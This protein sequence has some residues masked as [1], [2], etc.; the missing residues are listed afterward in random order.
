MSTPMTPE[1]KAWIDSATLYELLYKWRF[2]I[3]G[4]PYFQGD[5]GG[6]FLD[7]MEAKR[8]ANPHAWTQASKDMGWIG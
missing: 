3:S 4:D 2:A 7:V 5:T 8:K 6:Y 1:E